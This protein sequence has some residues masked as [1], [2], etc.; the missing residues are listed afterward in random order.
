M[1]AVNYRAAVLLI[2]VCMISIMGVAA[3]SMVAEDEKKYCTKNV[4]DAEKP[5]WA[6][7]IGLTYTF[8]GC[9]GLA[10]PGQSAC[11]CMIV[12]IETVVGNQMIALNEHEYLS[13]SKCNRQCGR[14]KKDK[15]YVCT[16]EE[17]HAGGGTTVTVRDCKHVSEITA[18]GTITSGRHKYKE[19]YQC[20]YVEEE[21]QLCRI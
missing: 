21:N 18:S 15:C 19:C 8:W 7:D 11:E 20:F 6:R 9:M 13:E 16:S 2:L 10:L 17:H 1:T 14:G 3:K 12:R 5:F 4:D